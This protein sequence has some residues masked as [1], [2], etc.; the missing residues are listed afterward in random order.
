MVSIAKVPFALFYKVIQSKPKFM[1][2]FTHKLKYYLKQME[3]K[4]AATK[5]NETDLLCKPKYDRYAIWMF[6]QRLGI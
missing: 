1:D 2:L 5:F 4:A 3:A 6:L